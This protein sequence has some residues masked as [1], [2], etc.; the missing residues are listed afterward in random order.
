MTL[1]RLIITFKP[2]ELVL[3]ALYRTQDGRKP[4]TKNRRREVSELARSGL[5]RVLDALEGGA[6]CVGA[7]EFTTRE[8]VL[9]ASASPVEAKLVREPR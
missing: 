9:L 3:H 5:T 8:D 7:S 1:Q 2:E 4:G 6:E